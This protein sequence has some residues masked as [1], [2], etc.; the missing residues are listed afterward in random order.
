MTIPTK[1]TERQEERLVG[2]F[3]IAQTIA[4]ISLI[5]CCNT[6]WFYLGNDREL[7]DTWMLYAG[8]AYVTNGPISAATLFIRLWKRPWVRRL[9]IVVFTA[10]L[11]LSTA[12]LAILFMER[13]YLPIGNH[14][15]LSALLYINALLILP[16]DLARGGIAL[17][18][19]WLLR[20]RCA[21][22]FFSAPHDEPV[23]F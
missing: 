18:L 4:F 3:L 17:R 10:Q 19:A 6:A 2:Y 21:S 15:A 12:S 5:P 7:H 11:M 14:G 16:L 13:P 8:A 23:R 20:G 22:A 1:E 9:L